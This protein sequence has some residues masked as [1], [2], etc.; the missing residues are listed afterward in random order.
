[1]SEVPESPKPPDRV[2]HAPGL[3]R[4]E[5]PT[6]FVTDPTKFSP[7]P[8][9]PIASGANASSATGQLRLW[10]EIEERRLVPAPTAFEDVHGAGK[11]SWIGVE[12]AISLCGSP[13]Q[14]GSIKFDQLSVQAKSEEASRPIGDRV[15]R[16]VAYLRTAYPIYVPGCSGS[17]RGQGRTLRQLVE[18]RA[19]VC[20]GRSADT[21]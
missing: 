7:L 17:V 15:M 2:D 6:A 19:A 8:C 14:I 5:G 20:Y 11:D 1:L 13:D 4:R 10:N 18:P 16:L 9:G 21:Q 12:E 3:D